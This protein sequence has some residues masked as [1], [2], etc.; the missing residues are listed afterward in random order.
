MGAE[1]FLFPTAASAEK[2]G[3]FTNTQRLLQFR[4][5]AVEPPGNARSGTW[6]MYHLSRRLKEKSIGSSV[7]ERGGR[8][9]E[10]DAHAILAN[11]VLCAGVKV[12]C[13]HMQ[14]SQPGSCLR[15]SNEG[16]GL[17]L[18]PFVSLADKRPR[19]TRFSL[20]CRL[21]VWHDCDAKRWQRPALPA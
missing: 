14:Q 8:L 10:I 16:T 7:R 19:V 18:C 11:R 12:A 3:T 15:H 9:G 13:T 5:E 21:S 17:P 1:Y 2:D 20:W 4:E 6:F